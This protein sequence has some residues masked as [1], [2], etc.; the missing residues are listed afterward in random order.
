MNFC[1]KFKVWVQ[2]ISPGSLWY[3]QMSFYNGLIFSDLFLLDV[4]GKMRVRV[5]NI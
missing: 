2:D 1:L 3:V 5:E 4:S